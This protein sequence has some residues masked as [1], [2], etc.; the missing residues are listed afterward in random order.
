MSS[1]VKE[2]TNHCY[3]KVLAFLQDFHLLSIHVL[4]LVLYLNIVV[5]KEYP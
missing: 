5:Y 2:G 1:A 4:V 3:N